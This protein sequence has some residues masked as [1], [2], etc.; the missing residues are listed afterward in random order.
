MQIAASEKAEVLFVHIVPIPEITRVGPL[1]AEGQSL[2]RRVIE[3]NRRV[4]SAY[5]DRLRARVGL[6][7]SQVRTLVAEDGSVRTRLERL[8]RGERADLVVMSA[9]GSSG[10]TDCPCGS[11]AEHALTHASTPVLIIRD[12]TRHRSKGLRP[13]PAR[14]VE[15]PENPGQ[16]TL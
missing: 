11:V 4:A 1:D 16:P 6:A 7:G 10:R 3:H 12:R 8:I 9:H 5:L 15:R 13:A 2:E 14:C